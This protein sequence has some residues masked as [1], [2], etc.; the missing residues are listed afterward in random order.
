MTALRALPRLSSPAGDGAAACAPVAALKGPGGFA[1]G[2]PA[3]LGTLPVGGGLAGLTAG[4][5]SHF[6]T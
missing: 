2:L 6:W 4:P 5:I 3:G 1:G